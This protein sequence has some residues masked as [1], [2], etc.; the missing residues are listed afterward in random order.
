MSSPNLLRVVKPVRSGEFREFDENSAA[1]LRCRSMGEFL[2]ALFP[3]RL[4]KFHPLLNFA[5][6][7]AF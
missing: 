4:T 3:R 1:D 2:P 7:H 5:Q 6:F